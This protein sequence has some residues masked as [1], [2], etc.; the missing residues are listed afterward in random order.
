M[1]LD[2]R[3]HELR[4]LLPSASVRQ[5]PVGDVWIGLSGEEL[6][7]NGILIER[8]AVADL[9]ASILDGRYRE[10][11]SRLLAHCAERQAHPL[12]IIEGEMD[13]LGHVRLTKSALMKHLTRLALRYHIA[14]FQTSCCELT[15]ELCS[16][17]EQQWNEDPTT[18]AM[19]AKLTYIETRGKS[20]QENTDDPHTFACSVLM[21][22]RGIS[23][24]GAQAVLEGCGGSLEGVMRASIDSLAK[25]Q[26]GK[27][28][29][30]KAKA[31]RLHTLLHHSRP[32]A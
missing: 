12:Y 8:K 29:F 4:A 23:A 28:K 25:I 18:F 13:R 6:A 19:P 9:E 16:L 26:V 7:A 22:C 15:A 1:L 27:Q 31:E 5:L 20:R 14:V 32:S 24:V 17:L 3:E 30:G 11:R 2:T 10:Q 21:C